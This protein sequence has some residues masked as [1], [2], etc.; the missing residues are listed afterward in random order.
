MCSCADN[1]RSHLNDGNYPA[2]DRMVR[3][4]RFN[5][6]DIPQNY[7]KEIEHGSLGRSNRMIEQSPQD[8]V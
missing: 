6:H 4:A 8:V 7:G 3:V 2:I 1:L 5:G